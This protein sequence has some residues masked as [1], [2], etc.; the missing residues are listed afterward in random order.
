MRHFKSF[1]W[2][3]QDKNL[4]TDKHISYL[5][6]SENNNL[7][8]KIKSKICIFDRIYVHFQCQGIWFVASNRI[9]INNIV[10]RSSEETFYKHNRYERNFNQDS[11]QNLNC[12][13]IRRQSCNAYSI[14]NSVTR[15]FQITIGEDKRNLCMLPSGYFWYVQH[16]KIN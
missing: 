3:Q 5:R 4:H 11:L 15:E 9:S 7:A 1:Y 2:N 12:S 6:I 14:S 10:N 13:K 16:F 8:P